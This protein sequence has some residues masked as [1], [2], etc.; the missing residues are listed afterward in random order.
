MLSSREYQSQDLARNN[1]STNVT[2]A[3]LG[4]GVSDTWRGAPD[5]R[6]RGCSVPADSTSVGSEVPVMY[7]RSSVPKDSDES[8]GTSTVCEAKLQIKKHHKA[9]LL[10]MCVVAAFIEHNL[11]RSLSPMIPAIIIDTCQARV[12]LYCVENDVLMISE[13][14]HWRKGSN[15]NVKGLS[16]LWA[17][18]N[19]RYKTTVC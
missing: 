19:H 11:H 15:F 3:P 13:K 8:R 5:V 18:I 16:V 1:V 10:K 4:M 14:F 6:L 12:A 7:G 17:M 9:Q 2:I